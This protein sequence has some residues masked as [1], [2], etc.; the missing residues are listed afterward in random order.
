[1]FICVSLDVIEIPKTQ[2]VLVYFAPEQLI[3]DLFPTNMGEGEGEGEQE[4]FSPY[5]F[6]VIMP[7]NFPSQHAFQFQQFIIFHVAGQRQHSSTF[8]V[9]KLHL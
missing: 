5:H 4:T 1:M 7:P 3:N 8:A 9:I 2:E 6:H